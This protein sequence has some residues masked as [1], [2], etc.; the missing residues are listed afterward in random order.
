MKKT[1]NFYRIHMNADIPGAWYLG[2]VLSAENEY[3][4]PIHFQQ[5]EKFKSTSGLQVVISQNGIPVDF[6]AT[7]NGIIIC[8]TRFA[9]VVEM[10]QLGAIQRIPVSVVSNDKQRVVYETGFEILNVKDV[11]EALD[12]Q[13]S[14]VEYYHPQ[15][16]DHIDNNIKSI[17]KIVLIHEKAQNH[18][19]FRLRESRQYLLVSDQLRAILESSNLTGAMFSDL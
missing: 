7:W 6:R 5:G 15:I 16:H 10:V 9:E 14:I 17:V 13:S 19:L 12:F 18:H 4:L 3:V 8:S 11:V 2:E 1:T